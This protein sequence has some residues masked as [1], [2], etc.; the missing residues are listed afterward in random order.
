[1][2]Q[3]TLKL[4]VS[5]QEQG[6]VVGV[7]GSLLVLPLVGWKNMLACSFVCFFERTCFTQT[8]F[9][10][11]FRNGG[12]ED[13]RQNASLFRC[14]YRGRVIRLW[15]LDVCTSTCRSKRKIF[16][17]GASIFSQFQP[18]NR[19]KIFSTA[20]ERFFS[21]LPR[22]HET[23]GAQQ[24]GGHEDL[25]SPVAVLSLDRP[26]PPCASVPPPPHLNTTFSS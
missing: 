12:E 16:A 9:C 3:Q 13:A 25:A 19:H 20:L 15:R 24:E 1:M 6:A 23:N 14:P 21:H 4:Q 8:A 10:R 11:V 7:N 18:K 17:P 2:D 26:P 22:C 5:Q